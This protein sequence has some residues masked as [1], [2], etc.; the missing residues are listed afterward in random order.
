MKKIIAI[1][2]VT[3]MAATT[4]FAQ[5][6]EPRHEIGVSYGAGVSLIGDGI[7]SGLVNGL[8]NSLGDSK[9]TNQKELG[10]FGVEYFY[11]LN[12]PRVAVG[13][14]ATFSRYGED[15]EKDDKKVGERRRTYISVMPA[16]KYYWVNKQH[17]G[18]Y[19]KAAVGAMYA[20]AKSENY[21]DN[22]SSKDNNFYFMYQAS[23]IGLEAG[24]THFR[25]FFEGGIGEQGIFLAGL[26]YKF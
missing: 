5:N 19:S 26:R 21:P 13:G 1:V 16:I 24:S 20:T 2:V 22:T 23:F 14:V 4:L 8:F 10:T 3:L 9:K 17:F 12:N 25:G 6:D 15:I 18:L 11:H 7:A